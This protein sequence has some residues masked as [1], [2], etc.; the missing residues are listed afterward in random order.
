MNVEYAKYIPWLPLLGALMSGLCCTN[1]RLDK[2]AA[3]F[4]IGGVASALMLALGLFPNM[5]AERLTISA[6]QLFNVAELDVG[7]N[8]LLDGLSMIMLLVVCG[9]GLM[10]MLYAAGYMSGDRGYARFFAFMALFIFAMTTLVLANNLVLLYLGWEGV[11]LCSY[12]LI[13]FYYERPAAVAAAKKAF[14]VN[15][16]GDLGFALGIFL[17]YTTYGSLNIDLITSQA[18]NGEHELSW[19]HHWIPWLLMMGALGKSAQLPL[20][21]WLP[22]AMEGPSPVSALIHAATMV[23][24]GVYMIARLLPIFQLSEFAL[25]AVAAIGGATSLLAATVALCQNDL[26]RIL[27]YST[28]SQLGYM[29]LGT[30]AL[31]TTGAIFH[32]MTH[33]FFKAL[34]FLTAGSVMHA[35]AG[36]LD[37]RKI[38]GLI[39]YMPVT[40]V[41]MLIG[42]LAL[43]GFP[44][45]SGFFSKDL[46]LAALFKQGLGE[47]GS[48][49]FLMLGVTGLLTAMLTAVYTF[50][51]WFRVFTGPVYFEHDS[52][53]HGGEMDSKH[54]PEPHEMPWWP[55]NIPLVILAAGS[56]FAGAFGHFGGEHH[57]WIGEMIQYSTADST[58][59]H[60][61]ITAISRTPEFFGMTLH[62][63]MMFASAALSVAGIIIAW[64]FHYRNR[65]AALKPAT[66]VHW[67]VKLLYRKYYVD[68]TYEYLLVRPLHTCAGICRQVDRLVIEPSVRLTGEL[69]QLAGLCLRSMQNGQLQSYGLSMIFAM[70]LIIILIF[71]AIA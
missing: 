67:I 12:L 16:I 63:T 14:I 43:A 68:E 55:M 27:A 51:L 13:G 19:M 41:L 10:V 59:S 3:C 31:E 42:C 11:G 22:D 54:H 8:Y 4:A 29:F 40:G 52:D 35:L 56:L 6:F 47:H 5:P 70:G 45:T 53:R 9:V 32:L 7:F 62:S 71:W 57:G 50:R 66:A 48:R 39:K 44:M 17:T 2:A 28:I 33:A 18:L 20:H 24:A 25:P 34:L 36:Q 21:V 61:H 38:S 60:T 65:N 69:T 58:K 37:I 64:Y 46:I 23:T 15:R 26:K 1:R 30:G 49:F